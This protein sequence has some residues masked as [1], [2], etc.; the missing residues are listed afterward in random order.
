MQH[1]GHPLQLLDGLGAFQL[2]QLM[3]IAG[4]NPA[5]AEIRHQK[6]HHVVLAQI[7]DEGRS[8]AIASIT[9]G[10]AG[11][12]QPPVLQAAG[13]G[14]QAEHEVKDHGAVLLRQAEEHGSSPM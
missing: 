6:A 1:F 3:A 13:Q 5:D 9:A 4:F 2:H 11:G 10:V 8:L 14:L 12:G 7:G